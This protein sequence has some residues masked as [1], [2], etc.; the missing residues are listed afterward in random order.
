MGAGKLI[1]YNKP[2]FYTYTYYVL[3]F[4]LV[5]GASLSFTWD[6]RPL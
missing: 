3:Q 2:I 5:M 1:T 6:E 4:G